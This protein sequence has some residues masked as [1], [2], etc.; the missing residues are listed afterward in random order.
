MAPTSGW[1][2]RPFWA[3][4]FAFLLTILAGGIW[5][6][7]LSANL[8]TT[9]NLPW[10]PLLMAVI[11]LPASRAVHRLPIR[12]IRVSPQP[13]TWALIAGSLALASLTGLWIVLYR[14]VHIAG[15][16]VPDFSKYP[17]VSVMLILAMASLVSSL[18][19]EAGFRGVFQGALEPRFGAAAAI[20]IQALVI[21]P[22]HG[23]TQGFA[24]PTLLFYFLVDTMLGTT[25]RLTQS[26]L[27]GIA[28]HAAGLAVFFGLIWPGDRD[29]VPLSQTGL[30]QW[31]WIHAV[32]AVIFGVL[33]IAAYAHL[34]QLTHAK[35]SGSI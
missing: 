15:N 1:S 18:A 12:A 24:W 29:R 26:I 7:L 6:A 23:L 33:A 21:A 20:A 17:L 25:A 4:V 11:L 3:G 9:P 31:F 16:A 32:Q 14:A 28:I 10:A 22:A 30:D 8:A 27:P 2:A 13:L 5:T 34:A 19:E 35:R